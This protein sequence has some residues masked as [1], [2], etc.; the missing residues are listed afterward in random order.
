MLIADAVRL[1]LQKRYLLFPQVAQIEIMRR[2]LRRRSL[3]GTEVIVLS[4]Q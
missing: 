4:L 1:F 3:A 2:V